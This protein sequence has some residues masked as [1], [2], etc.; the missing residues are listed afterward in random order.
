[1]E[2]SGKGKL[3]FS[4]RREGVTQAAGKLQKLGIITYKRGH[5]SVIDRARL[6]T[7]SCECYK[8]V[9]SETDRLESYIQLN[10]DD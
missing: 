8:V 10:P 3:Y 2:I 7:Q 9:K 4:V 1:M 6:E 5:I